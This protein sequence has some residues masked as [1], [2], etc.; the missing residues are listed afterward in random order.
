[1]GADSIIIGI[2]AD[3]ASSRS[4]NR[5]DTGVSYDAVAPSTIYG[6][7]LSSIGVRRKDR[8]RY[9]GTGI[10]STYL[11]MPTIQTELRSESKPFKKN[12]KDEQYVTS[13]GDTKT[14]QHASQSYIREDE[15]LHDVALVIKVVG[16]LASA[17]NEAFDTNWANVDRFGVLS[18][19]ESDCIV[20]RFMRFDTVEEAAQFERDYL[21]MAGDQYAMLADE[22]PVTVCSQHHEDAVSH[23]PL[24]VWTGYHGDTDTQA[25]RFAFRDG[26]LD[27]G[28]LITV[29][30]PVRCRQ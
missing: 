22:E 14:K 2:Y 10:A 6:M 27:D 17:L 4:P 29:E 3:R 16:E 23:F 12:G 28:D 8:L 25:M 7:L 18:L 9:S 24:T 30:P 19:G 13:Y 26:F 5:S 21:L 1:M 15:F 11:R 20:S